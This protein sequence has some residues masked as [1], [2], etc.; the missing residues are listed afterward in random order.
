VE[1]RERILR[2]IVK[3][4]VAPDLLRPDDAIG[5]VEQ[6]RIAQT[7]STPVMELFGG[8]AEL[9]IERAQVLQEAEIKAQKYES[10]RSKAV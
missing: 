1:N 9:W 2:H 7:L 8:S 10:Q 4:I 5:W 3:S 6:I